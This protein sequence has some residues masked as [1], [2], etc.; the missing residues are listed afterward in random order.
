MADEPLYEV[1]M[2]RRGE[3]L[4]DGNYTLDEIQ[5][6]ITKHA[7]SAIADRAG[8]AI[9]DAILNGGTLAY[10]GWAMTLRKI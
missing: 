5:G 9:V 3:I 8:I 7:P 10:D 2:H 1:M 4:F 6:A